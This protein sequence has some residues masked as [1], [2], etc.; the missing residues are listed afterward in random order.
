VQTGALTGMVAITPTVVVVDVGV[1]E[2]N[3]ELVVVEP[4]SA[5]STFIAFIVNTVS[6]ST[7]IASP[8]GSPVQ[9]P[10]CQLKS[11]EV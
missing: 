1:V 7:K 3:G 2:L 11:V 10:Q 4:S 9:K 8:E 6:S 5:P